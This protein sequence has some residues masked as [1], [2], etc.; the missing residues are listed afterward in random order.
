MSLES[1]IT[2]FFDDRGATSPNNAPNFDFIPH[3]IDGFYATNYTV[4][5]LTGSALYNAAREA[6]CKKP[7]TRKQAIKEAHSKINHSAN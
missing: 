2:K 4:R 1:A 5:G 7:T 6:F 3:I